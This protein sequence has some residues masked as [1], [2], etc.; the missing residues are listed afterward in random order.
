VEKKDLRIFMLKKKLTIKKGK[1]KPAKKI[2]RK[3]GVKKT[4]KTLNK[5]S[6]VKNKKN[7]IK[8]IRKTK[9]KNK[10]LNKRKTKIVKKKIKKTKIAKTTI[11]PDSDDIK[12]LTNKARSKGF[13]TETELLLVF[14]EVEEYIPEFEKFLDVLD[15]MAV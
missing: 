15:K 2:S 10:L 4:K 12:N 3:Q 6:N 7:T 13:I 9:Q 14:P 11:L 8:K 1:K 5:K